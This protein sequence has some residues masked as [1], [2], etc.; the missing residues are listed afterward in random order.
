MRIFMIKNYHG[1]NSPYE[2]LFGNGAASTSLT[3]TMTKATA[4]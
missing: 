2:K 4:T 1:E 3:A